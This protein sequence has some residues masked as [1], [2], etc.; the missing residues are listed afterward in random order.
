[1]KQFLVV[2]LALISLA[3][4]AKSLEPL[5]MLAGQPVWQAGTPMKINVDF[6]GAHR[7]MCNNERA[8]FVDAKCP[9]MDLWMSWVQ[10]GK[11][12]RWNIW[13][14]DGMLVKM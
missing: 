9:Q 14:N 7:A 6:D 3:P 8:R 2:G 5:A 1:M 4:C 12:P 13:W 10:F 11:P